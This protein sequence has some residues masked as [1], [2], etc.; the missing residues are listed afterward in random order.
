MKNLEQLLLELPPELQQEVR[1]FAEFL[2]QTR[3]RPRRRKLRLSWAGGLSEFRERF[4]SLDLQKKAV[5][6]WGDRCS[7]WTPTSG[8]NFYSSKKFDGT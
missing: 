2:L 3:V 4:T 5:E 8:W 6:W 7:W 1:D